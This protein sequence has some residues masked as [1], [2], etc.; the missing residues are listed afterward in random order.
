MMLFTAYTWREW[1]G[2]AVEHV[3]RRR[4]YQGLPVREGE[5]EFIQSL[6]PEGMLVA[7]G[8]LLVLAYSQRGRLRG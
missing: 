1:D 6:M 5:I 7:C 4:A 3:V 2:Y 8:L